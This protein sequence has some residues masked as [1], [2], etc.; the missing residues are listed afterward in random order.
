MA[1]AG[2]H[3]HR[4]ATLTPAHDK[5]FQY[6]ARLVEKVLIFSK[7]VQCVTLH[8]ILDD[9]K[10]IARFRQL[11]PLATRTLRF[12]SFEDVLLKY[13]NSSLGALT[14]IRK[15]AGKEQREISSFSES[16]SWC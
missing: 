16:S 15:N 14:K 8:S 10:N 1:R 4:W 2:C 3:A 12:I 7:D 11:Y 5:H 9:H 13:A 6:L